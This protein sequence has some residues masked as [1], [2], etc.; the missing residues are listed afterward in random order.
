MA[1][2]AANSATYAVTPQAALEW[3][4]HA[5]PG[6][7]FIYFTGPALIQAL[8]VVDTARKLHEA[9]EVIFVQERAGPGI[10]HYLMLKRRN[11]EPKVLSRAAID[12]PVPGTR[13]DEDLEDLMAVLRRLANLGLECPTNSKLADMAG[14]KD[15]ESARY[16][17]GLLAACGRINVTTPVQGPRIVTIVASGR[18]TARG[19]EA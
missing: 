3:A 11:A 15:A 9:G 4:R 17:L 1:G 13:V 7:K 19:A 12:T 6:E 5:R 8:P 14:L 2:A 16:R 10:R 18:S